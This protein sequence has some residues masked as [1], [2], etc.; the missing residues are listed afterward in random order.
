MTKPQIEALLALYESARGP[1]GDLQDV[2]RTALAALAERD[3]AL[4]RLDTA[5]EAHNDR[6]QALDV[7][8]A[9]GG[10]E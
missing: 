3:A 1:D 7:A 5:C 2:A 8:L 10:P 6:Q 4:A 9:E